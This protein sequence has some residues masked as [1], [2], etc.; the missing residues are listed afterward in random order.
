MSI[1]TKGMYT[2]TNRQYYMLIDLMQS[3]SPSIP[4][5][6]NFLVRKQSV[7]NYEI[8]MTTANAVI[9]RKNS[10]TVLKKK[11]V[12]IGNATKTLKAST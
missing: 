2:P 5:L 3:F 1:I 11:S 7:A 4:I 9:I 12:R 6:R 10:S 8:L